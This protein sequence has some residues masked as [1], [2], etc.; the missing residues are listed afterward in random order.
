MRNSPAPPGMVSGLDAA[1]NLAASHPRFAGRN[2]AEPGS[3]GTM[4]KVAY[5]FLWIFAF[6]MPFQSGSARVSRQSQLW[7]RL[8]RMAPQSRRVPK[9]RSG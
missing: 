3:S 4:P 1:R 5:F 8:G 2:R 9:D 6:A 7:F